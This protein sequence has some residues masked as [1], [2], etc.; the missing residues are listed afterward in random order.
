MDCTDV[1][2]TKLI[3]RFVSFRFGKHGRKLRYGAGQSKAYHQCIL[4]ITRPLTAAQ[5]ELHAQW[6]R[7][8]VVQCAPQPRSASLESRQGRGGRGPGG[9]T[10]SWKSQMPPGL[11][12]AGGRGKVH[13][14]PLCSVGDRVA[15]ARDRT[16]GPWSHG[17]PTAKHAREHQKRGRTAGTANFNPARPEQATRVWGSPTNSD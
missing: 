6:N 3:R 14:R 4:Y 9:A 8:G 16:P 10:P 15:V 12:C 1:W 2:A 5:C 13:S 7:S 11:R 17:D